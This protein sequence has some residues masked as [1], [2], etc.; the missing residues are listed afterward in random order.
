MW[1]SE[2]SEPNTAWIQY[3]FDVP[4][5][6]HQMLVWNYNGQGFNR[7]TGFKEVIVKYSLDGTNWTPIDSVS[8]FEIA[9]GTP[10][11]AANTTV[12]FNGVPV[13][14]IHIGAK[15]NWSNGFIDQYGLSEVQFLY[16]PL[17]ARIPV[18]DDGATEVAIDVSLNWKTGREAAEHKVYLSADSQS[19]ENSTAPAETVLETSYGPLSLDLGQTYYWRVDEVNNA[20]TVPIW[21][22]STWSFTTSEYLV[23]D[24]FESY[25]DIEAGEEGSNLIYAT[26]IDGYVA[27]PDVRTNGSTVG[28]IE[29]FQ[30]T[31]ETD[32][33]H[34]GKQSVPVSY[35]N[36]IASLSEV[37][38]S[39]NDLAVGSDW[40]VGA[41][42]VLTLWFYGDPNNA[43]TEQMYVKVNSS[44]KVI[45]GGDL[46]QTDWQE[47][48]VDLASLGI[49]LSNVEYVACRQ[50]CAVGGCT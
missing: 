45:Y 44:N 4:Y 48:S 3:E 24:D 33:V 9:P 37:T 50:Q 32:I 38:V 31:M 27:P 43:A 42:A 36:T 1:L 40:T 39:S 30:P 16:I 21:E 10:A 34:S 26:W 14:Y 2:V 23:V 22:G 8:E 6:L 15:S 49:D 13:R 11:Y 25:N 28:Y 41:P 47:F 46:T 12:D 17:S 5:K 20:N 18:P 29:A 7:M 35:D 19:V